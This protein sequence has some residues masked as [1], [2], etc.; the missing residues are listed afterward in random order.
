[1]TMSPSIPTRLVFD[2]IVVRLTR[3]IYYEDESV[4]QL[5]VRQTPFPL[6]GGAFR[7]DIETQLEKFQA[8]FTRQTTL[9]QFFSRFDIS[10]PSFESLSDA[11]ALGQQL[12]ALLPLAFQ[13]S[14]PRVVQSIFEQGHGLR[15]ILESRAGDKA[16]RLLSLPW[17]LLFFEATNMVLTR[18][19]RV[20]IE[21]RL[22]ETLRRSPRQMQPPFNI[23]H[24]IAHSD[25][26]PQAYHIDAALQSTER[27]VIRQ[28]VQPG[29]YRLVEKPGA[30]ETLL[31]ALREDTY[32]IVHFL[33]HGEIVEHRVEPDIHIQRGYL[34]FIDTEN[35]TQWVTGEQ[36]QHFLEFTPTVQLVVLN[37]CHGGA[38][39]ARN[40]A[41]E[42]IYNGLPY[43]VAIQGDILQ[44][45][46]KHFIE[47][48]Y[49]ELQR[50]N[51]I[52][53]AVAVGRAAIAA[54]VPQTL[55]WC[56]PVLYTNVG[57]DEPPAGIK[58]A[59]RLWQW[60]SAPQSR[61]WL[62]RGNLLMG[63]LHLTIGLLLLMSRQ[64]IALSSMPL[65]NVITAVAAIL[66][67]L[68]T[69]LFYR[70]AT[71]TALKSWVFTSR[72][73]LLARAFGAAALSFGLASWYVW[74]LWLLTIATGLWHI[75]APLAQAILSS[76]IF[77]PGFL[78][79][80]GL[81]YSQMWG[82]TRAFISEAC[83]EAPTFEWSELVLMLGGYLLL[84]TPWL[85][86]TF[87]P[88]YASPP[89]G[90]IG[91]GIILSAIGYLLWKADK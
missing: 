80:G 40:V 74:S 29:K 18:S 5:E 27:E 41:L 43:V 45:S 22:L 89:W 23:V 7:A 30:V 61:K 44:E 11:Q 66:P 28:A 4:F 15:L 1:M 34:R 67:V 63:G 48:F 81:S 62:G 70:N 68:I 87:Q 73:R 37:A 71:P 39:V 88:M 84:F 69:F 75:L 65:V 86:I 46:A 6:S 20:L 57:L 59:E 91:I 78:L 52:A 72:L 2:T 9:S 76:L 60:M 85:I 14:F 79:S 82:H 42:L 17:E 55:D 24:V 90:N 83:I 31:A 47:T 3:Q 50:G 8:L 56:L 19:P 26:A 25:K 16:D 21:R 54:Y 49:A 33:G 64:A 58:H 51:D 36:L 53:C 12:Y 10:T 13:Q 32:H 77:V 38:N 35:N